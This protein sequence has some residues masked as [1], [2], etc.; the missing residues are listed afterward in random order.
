VADTD[1]I[2]DAKYRCGWNADRKFW[3]LHICGNHLSCKDCNK[4]RYFDGAAKAR[5]GG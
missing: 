2:V 1:V 3:D 4:A 5:S